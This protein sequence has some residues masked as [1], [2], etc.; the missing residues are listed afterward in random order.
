MD[1]IS[2][3]GSFVLIILY[4][5]IDRHIDRKEGRDKLKVREYK[6]ETFV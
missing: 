4:V 3:K 6:R 2:P 1:I 5:D